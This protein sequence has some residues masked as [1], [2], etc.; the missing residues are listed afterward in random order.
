MSEH[1]EHAG[2]RIGP[3]RWCETHK[4]THGYLY[5]CEFYDL[6]TLDQIRQED[7]LFH[8]ALGRLERR[9]R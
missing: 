3:V 8:A 9:T 4:Q 2:E 1:S 7:E 6:E 5:P